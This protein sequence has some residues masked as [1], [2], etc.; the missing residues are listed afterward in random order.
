M[1]TP[2][3]ENAR[4]EEISCWG[5]EQRLQIWGLLGDGLPGSGLGSVGFGG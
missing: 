3:G 5:S 1:K 4:G 2:T